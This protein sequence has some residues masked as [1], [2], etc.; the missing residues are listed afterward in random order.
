M[1]L[2]TIKD[3]LTEEEAV[4]SLM[5]FAKRPMDEVKARDFFN[6]LCYRLTFQYIIGSCAGIVIALQAMY[7]DYKQFGF[8]EDYQLKYSKLFCDT[9]ATDVSNHFLLST[10]VGALFLLISGARMGILLSLPSKNRASASVYACT[11]MKFFRHF[12]VVFYD[13]LII[14]MINQSIIIVL[15]F[16]GKCSMKHLTKENLK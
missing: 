5:G 2:P 11:V 1:F 10:E 12:T 8:D 9:F 13:L 7:E 6:N 15:M 4:E 16:N 3:G 14:A